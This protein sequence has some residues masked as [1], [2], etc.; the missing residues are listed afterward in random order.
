MIQG[1]DITAGNGTGGESIYGPQ[2]DDE[3]F[4]VN[5]TDPFLL[6]M[7]NR[8]PNTNSSQF[9]ITTVPTPHLDQ[10]HVVFGRVHQGKSLVRQIEN[11]LTD[12]K[13]KPYSKVTISQ[14]GQL[15]RGKEMEG[16]AEAYGGDLYPDWPEDLV[17][18]EQTLTTE[19]VQ[20]VAQEVKTLGTEAFKRKHFR[21]AVH[22]Y[23]KVP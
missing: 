6:S 8:G 18:E 2:F 21:T 19:F 5:H 1:G 4:A 23:E 12:S 13:D 15:E 16:F 10:K 17:D 20:K 7:A 11:T 22:K 3:C 9:F 14:C